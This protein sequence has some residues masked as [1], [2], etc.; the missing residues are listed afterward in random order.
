MAYRKGV[1]QTNN[2]SHKDPNVNG[3]AIPVE[4]N[5]SSEKHRM[6]KF[7]I[8]T[9]DFNLRLELR[10]MFSEVFGTFFLVVVAAG[11]D[12]VNVASVGAVGRV[13]AVVAP[14]VM[15]MAVI[16]F[17]GE[18]SGAHLNPAVTI[19]FAA[20]GD[21]PWKRVPGYIGAQLLGATVACLLLWFM[22][23]TVGM[24]GAT[25]PGPGFS[26]L[27]AMMMEL[28]LTLGLVS[29]ILGT[30][31]ESQN[32]GPLS[33]L[34]VGGYIALAGLWGSPIS[35]ASMNPVRSFGPDLVILNFAHYWV[36]ILGPIAGAL[37]AVGI[38]YVLRGS[39]GDET[40]I[41]AAQGWFLRPLAKREDAKFDEA[42]SP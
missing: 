21:F 30:A 38:A 8:D 37:L 20:R 3:P 1:V 33:A 32:V 40:A 19:G 35:G 9:R 36:Y 15:V 2:M 6:Q 26:D 24:L 18:V 22:F 7:E 10:R 12:V 27:Q 17:M 29:T 13:A 16:L 5:H 14:G 4:P 28:V 31:S 39:G 25:E 23:G 34:A 42:E 11:A 41:R